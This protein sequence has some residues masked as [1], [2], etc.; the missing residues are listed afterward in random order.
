MINRVKLTR[1]GSVWDSRNL[2]LCSKANNEKLANENFV[3]FHEREEEEEEK[4]NFNV[5]KCRC[6]A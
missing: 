2:C 5:E 6:S 4:D 3:F 1:E